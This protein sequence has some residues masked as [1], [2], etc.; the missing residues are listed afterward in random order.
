MPSKGLDGENFLLVGVQEK[1]N[2]MRRLLFG[3][4]LFLWLE[5]IPVHAEDAV[6]Y[7]ERGEGAFT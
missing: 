5:G 4:I 2:R 1:Q 7:F 6:E 3:L